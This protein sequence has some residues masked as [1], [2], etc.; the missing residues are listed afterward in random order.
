MSTN[1]LA[2]KR[3]AA[4]KPDNYEAKRPNNETEDDESESASQCGNTV[5][6]RCVTPTGSTSVSASE[7]DGQE[8]NVRQKKKK[9]KGSDKLPIEQSTLKGS[10]D[11]EVA[12]RKTEEEKE[13]PPKDREK[14][15]AKTSRSESQKRSCSLNRPT[16]NSF[17]EIQ[18]NSLQRQKSNTKSLSDLSK[19]DE[20]KQECKNVKENEKESTELRL[21]ENE[22]SPRSKK[23][24]VK[25]S[26]KEKL[27]E[28][29]KSKLNWAADDSDQLTA[30]ELEPEPEER[31]K[32]GTV[33]TTKI[34]AAATSN[35]KKKPQSRIIEKSSSLKINEYH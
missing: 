13:N 8:G 18:N 19:E 33:K 14:L 16:K 23:P 10:S 4:N 29:P 11:E 7:N 26:P 22:C 6:N 31:I 27:K 32:S 20:V 21:D 15:R 17:E 34:H 25:T 12:T 2:A 9:E 30:V 35:P 3:R 24:C 1:R 28:L 5:Y